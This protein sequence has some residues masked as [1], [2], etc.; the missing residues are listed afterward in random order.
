MIDT[1]PTNVVWKDRK[2][3]SGTYLGPVAYD[4]QARC[5][6]MMR[7]MQ[8]ARDSLPQTSP[9]EAEGTTMKVFLA[10]EFFFRGRQGAYPMEDVQLAIA[11]LQRMA[12]DDQ[13]SDWMFG[14]GT[15]LGV[16]AP[17][18]G[19]PPTIDPAAVQEVYNFTLVQKGG[20]ANAGDPGARVVMKELKS[21]ID[22]I[23]QTANPG[24]LLLGD[25]EYA[26]AGDKG[27]GRE[28]QVVNYDGAGIFDLDGITWGVEI[29]LD[30][31][32]QVQ[33]LQLSPQ[34]PGASQVQVQLVPSCGMTI[35]DASAIAGPGGYVFNCDGIGGG[36]SAL[37]RVA[38]PNVAILPI[39]TTAVSND[40][41]TVAE[42]SPVV[43]IPIAELFQGGAGRIVIYPVQTLPPAST[44]Q[45][46]IVTLNWPASTDYQFKF[47]LI[48]DATGTYKTVLVEPISKKTSFSY[49]NYFLP[50]VMATY[51]K[52]AQRA[53][54]IDPTLAPDVNIEMKVTPGGSGFDY[55]IRCEI[56]LPDFEFQGAAFLFNNTTAGLPPQTSW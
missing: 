37:K 52:E 2:I 43:D 42:A 23:A 51:S 53:K 19:S 38:T 25:V 6:L 18:P 44:V 13:W 27:P 20:S 48:Y 40:P 46:S 47:D 14:Y 35:Q 29:C 15:I 3:H 31:H 41:I 45:G 8:T 16:S 17:A 4:V 7:A 28:Q 22:F 36:S 24:G 10:P 5:E 1:A 34:L 12:A 39:S 55:A 21:G 9:P 11:I 56:D 50:L 33:R 26:R 49:Y 32:T 30:H 54:L